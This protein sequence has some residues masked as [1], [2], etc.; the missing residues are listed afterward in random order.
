MLC[1][2]RILIKMLFRILI[3]IIIS[4]SL[5]FSQEFIVK[6]Y[7]RAD[8][9]PETGI[10]DIVQDTNGVMW[11]ATKKG[12]LSYD[13]YEWKNVSEELNIP[14]VAYTKFQKD[15]KN[16]IWCVPSFF[17]KSPILKYNGKRWEKI[18]I[19]PFKN[20]NW[21]DQISSI[22]I[23]YEN[24]ET[25]I[26]LGTRSLGIAIYN[27]KDWNLFSTKNGIPSDS[28]LTLTRYNNRF[29]AF[30]NEAIFILSP[31]GKLTDSKITREIPS[32][33]VHNTCIIN[34]NQQEVI[35]LLGETWVGK[36][37]NNHFSL[38]KDNLHLQK[39]M[40]I[41]YF[42]LAFDGGRFIYFG[43]SLSL[44]LLDLVENTFKKVPVENIPLG[45]TSA[46]ID[47]ESNIW[48]ASLRELVKIKL[49]E[50]KNYSP[51]D[52]LL[53][54]EVSAISQLN[55]SI[56]FFGHNTGLS[57]KVGEKFKR[58]PFRYSSIEKGIT[59]R[60]LDVDYNT[61][62]NTL[63]VTS[64]KKGIGSIKADLSIEWLSYG[65]ISNY[66]SSKIGFR[67]TNWIATE[68]G[69]FINHN[70]IT[71]PFDLFSEKFVV[72]KIRL[73]PDS[74]LV[75][76]TTRGLF[77][78][79]DKKLE[80]FRSKSTHGN[81]LFAAKQ[82]NSDTILVGSADGLY[83]CGSDSLYKY[84][85]GNFSIDDP[86]YFITPDSSN[87]FWFGTD[88]GVIK[89]DG[90]NYKRYT[91]SDGLSGNETN[92]AAGFV[93]NKGRLWIGTDEGLSVYIGDDYSIS[94]S[95]PKLKLLNF[96]DL[97]NNVFPID[98]TVELESEQNNLIFHY[99]GLSFINED[100]A[101]YHVRLVSMDDDWEEEFETPQNFVRFNNLASGDYIFSVRF[102]NAKKVWSDWKSS[103]IF[104]I[105]RP[106]YQQLWFILLSVFSLSFVVITLH[107]IYSQR[108]Y[109]KK[110][111]TEVAN[112]TR[113]LRESQVA[114]SKSKERY[115]GLIE[116]QSELVTRLDHNGKFT[117]VN[118]AMRKMFERKNN[119]FK[120]MKFTD[121]VTRD[122]KDRVSETF[123]KLNI[124]PYRTEIE[125]RA[126]TPAG[127]K[128]FRWEFYAIRDEKDN[129]NEIQA[130]GRDITIQRELEEEL[131]RRVDEKTAELNSL[132]S[133]SPLSIITFDDK[134]VLTDSNNSAKY[135]FHLDEEKNKLKLSDI[136]PLSENEFTEYTTRLKDIIENGGM[137]ITKSILIN[138]VINEYYKTLLTHW[139]IY[140]IYTVE[141]ENKSLKNLV[142]LVDDVTEQHQV[143]EIN[144]KLSEEKIRTLTFIR[145]RQEERKRISRDLH[146]GLGQLLS[147]AKL[148]LEVMDKAREGKKKNVEDALDLI[149]RAGNEMRNVLNDLQPKE[150]DDY[151]LVI[152]L[153]LLIENLKNDYTLNVD[154]S[155][156]NFEGFENRHKDVLLYRIIQEA[157]TNI[158]KHSKASSAKLKIER[159]NKLLNIEI[160]DDGIGIS[161]ESLGKL[162]SFGVENMKE[163]CELLDG[164][165]TFRSA[166]EQGVKIYMEIPV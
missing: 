17:W 106:F 133:Q 100:E 34:D 134:G 152:S 31:D 63:Y 25:I 53:E 136:F 139:L 62:N 13:G 11:F 113:S 111:E 71:Q 135:L 125:H 109:T 60:I 9:L 86:V 52:G 92:R 157:F 150:I 14:Q 66:F 27:G 99:R 1:K 58:I 124:F 105:N 21:Y 114:L 2:L 122:D 130:V 128:W 36:I 79:L 38:I 97:K 96:T 64:L 18:E 102:K 95:K 164:K 89:W 26:A 163:R 159:N 146:D 74:S 6:K 65:I 88:F 49:S 16:N 61:T 23:V 160:I 147:S 144:K 165:F 81:D 151:G 101:V 85:N 108:K 126:K 3:L 78:Y 20:Q 129:I 107:S 8:G 43:N 70:S 119:T 54:D 93:D 87:N 22:D 41:D 44:Y 42:P 10:Y 39:I 50:F 156:I 110:L 98:S 77:I 137:L 45:I 72:R 142:L 46:Y 37:E 33:R 127:V 131:E 5:L 12:L 24:N 55:D 166:P 15:E 76:A 104:H 90:K 48:L 120:E 154:F 84:Y 51:S 118:E 82:L 73:F 35:T 59:N 143:E 132:I 75:M 47:Y 57:F 141:D 32:S 40:F 112:R 69:L 67:D 4:N 121:I 138:R 103:A 140:R 7:G 123:E 153:E 83:F 19:L 94:E 116:S 155:V 117:F 149:L 30:S 145:S 91:K 28:I 80:V 158:V 56:Y 29:L 162:D 161:D 148:K 115:K 68:K